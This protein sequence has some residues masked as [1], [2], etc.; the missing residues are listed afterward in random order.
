EFRAIPTKDARL[1]ANLISAGQPSYLESLPMILDFNIGGEE[2]NSA[3][4]SKGAFADKLQATLRFNLI[5][6]CMLADP[7]AFA[8]LGLKLRRSSS[9]KPLFSITAHYSFPVAFK[10]AVEARFNLFE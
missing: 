9:Q 5:G 10:H 3:S 4:T 6:A 8:D 1:Q 2:A 7:D